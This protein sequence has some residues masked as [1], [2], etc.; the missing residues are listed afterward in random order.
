MWGTN[1]HFNVRFYAENTILFLGSTFTSSLISSVSLLPY[2]YYFI[3][4]IF[5]ISELVQIE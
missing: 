1:E 4:T 2:N 3:I 5:L